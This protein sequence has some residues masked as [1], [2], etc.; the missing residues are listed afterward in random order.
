MQPY[1]LCFLL[2]LVFHFIVIQTQTFRW[3]D[4]I[5]FWHIHRWAYPTPATTIDGPPCST[6]LKLKIFSFSFRERDRHRNFLSRRM[7]RH[8]IPNLTQQDFKDFFALRPVADPRSVVIEKRKGVTGQMVDS[9]GNVI[10]PDTVRQWSRKARWESAITEFTDSIT[11][12]CIISL[13]PLAL[14]SDL[15][16]RLVQ[17]TF[18]DSEPRWR[19]VPLTSCIEW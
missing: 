12:G 18:P 11:E 13:L 19:V 7:S 8:G 6:R 10:G 1:C 2:I 14:E 15:N 17:D 9:S 4:L 5:T 16:M 3:L